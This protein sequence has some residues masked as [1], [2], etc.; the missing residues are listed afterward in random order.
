MCLLIDNQLNLTGDIEVQER[1][2]S[3]YALVQYLKSELD[4][5]RQ[6]GVDDMMTDSDTAPI[7]KNTLIDT[8][9]EEMTLLFTGDLNPV[10]PK[11]QKKVM[12][13]E[14][15]DID[16]WIN[17]PLSDN[18]SSSEDEKGD[19]LFVAN[20]SYDGVGGQESRKSS[21]E[22][23][24][25]DVERARR[26]RELEQ[27]H[28]PNYLKSSNKKSKKQTPIE[29]EIEDIPIAEIALDIP[30]KI[31]STKRSD[32]YLQQD[33]KGSKSKRTSK[34]TSKKHKNKLS[35]SS[36]ESEYD[37]ILPVQVSTVVEIP[38]GAT[39][40]DSDNDQKDDNDP[41]KSLNID[42]DI[43]IQTIMPEKSTKSKGDKKKSHATKGTA[44][45]PEK[46]TK[47]RKKKHK[48]EK[49]QTKVSKKKEKK[50]VNLFDVEEPNAELKEDKHQQDAT[51]VKTKSE[52]SK[53]KHSHDKTKKQSKLKKSSSKTGYEDFS[54]PTK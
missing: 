19:F 50:D 28:N 41:H 37:E 5:E 17:S 45:E 26:S 36:S 34:K 11:A 8:I 54:T 42:L 35:Y 51:P 44:L 27:S 21:P 29:D 23:T 14:G 43:P 13:P 38:E 33:R 22:I 49:D 39:L 16:E 4:Q 7:E 1:S 15:L 53:K 30:L 18:V 9:I 46:E 48:K 32:K 52:S 10:A 47:D 20:H 25:E 31:H 40:S 12:L 2:S 6:Q 3:A 24:R